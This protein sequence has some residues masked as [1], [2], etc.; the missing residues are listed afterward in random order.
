MN[1]RK[2]RPHPVLALLLALSLLLG[3]CR[4]A[5]P[6]PQPEPNETQA[7]AT[8]APARTQEGTSEPIGPTIGPVQTEVAPTQPP[9]PQG[10]SLPET[11]FASFQ[12]SPVRSEPSLK[13]EAIAADLS[14]VYNP[15]LLSEE[16]RQR[17]GSDGFV[18]TPGQEKEF[19]TVYEKARYANVPVFVTSDSLLHS[20][21]LLFDKILRTAEREKFIPLLRDLNA[22]LLETVEAQYQALKGT[23]WED[24]ALRTLAF[25]GVASQLLDPSV[26]APEAARELVEAELSL[27]EEAAGIRSSPIFHLNEFGEDYTQYI[28]RGHYTLS[29]DLKAYFKSMMWY[30]RMTFRLKGRDP[31]AGRAETRSALLLAQAL[32]ETQVNGKPALEVWAG[33]YSPTVFFVGR[34]DD[35]TVIQYLEVMDKIYGPNAST[36]AITDESRLDA[37]I[38]E[39]YKLPPPKILGLVISADEEEESAT[40]GMRFMGQRFVPDAYVFRQLIYRNVSTPENRRGLPMGLD[41]LAAMGS[42]RAY[43]VLDEL[44]ETQ[45]ARYPEQMEKVRSWMGGLTVE[46]WTETLYNGWLYSFYPL[47]DPPGAGYPQ[48]MQSAAW[49]DKQMNTV[50]GSWAELKHDTI[51][52]AKQVY[53]EMGGG[54]PPPQPV[55]PRGYVEPVPQFYARLAALTRMTIE[56]LGSRGLLNE[57]DQQLLERLEALV[58]QFQEMAEKELRGEPL[59]AEEYDTIRFYGG[60]LEYFVMA[61]AD[62]DSDDPFGQKYMDEEPQAAVVA[63]VATDP[64]PDND[65]AANPVVLEEAVGRIN[66]IHVVAPRVESDGSITLQVAKGGVFSYYEFPWPADDRL[67]DEKWRAM[68]DE[69]QAP[70]PPSWTESFIAEQGEYEGLRLGVLD[71]QNLA[72]ILVWEWSGFVNGAG[73][74]EL[75]PDYSAIQAEVDALRAA[76]QYQG[77]QLVSSSFVSYDLQAE[78]RAVV[79]VREEWFDQLFE[80]AVPEPDGTPAAERGPYT[81]EATYSL[82]RRPDAAGNLK[83]TVTGVSYASPPPEWEPR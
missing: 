42:E 10:L 44:G 14:N 27:V 5:T 73:K 49:V 60:D 71:Y 29:E 56:G 43:A 76:E 3:A 67:T 7:P 53:A 52:Y 78:D 50:L 54:P 62:S 8:E 75:Y 64:D 11:D 13:H 22:A 9:P 1:T 18:V 83:W 2:A 37:F 28:P 63:D 46:E 55:P 31:E 70:A 72:T 48:F 12:E 77:H 39:A 15:F 33:L 65:G 82:E 57:A 69:G 35:L 36:Q 81:L 61:S 40:K 23:D 16:Q 51:L 17:L 30:G 24:A 45:Y 26:Q 74:L 34:S 6:T 25:V 68:L 20:Y 79:T 80:G 4:Q 32:R 58:R 19:F 41:L 66:E 59:T 38:E 21:H 47:L